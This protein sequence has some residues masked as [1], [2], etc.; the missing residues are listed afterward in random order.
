MSR[1]LYTTTSQNYRD[2]RNSFHARGQ[3]SSI[4]FFERARKM[5]KTLIVRHSP[6]FLNGDVIKS[7]YNTFEESYI[8]VIDYHAVKHKSVT[9]KIK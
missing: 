9:G 4:Q 8:K 7:P 3:S 2:Y 5:K 1:C 6:T